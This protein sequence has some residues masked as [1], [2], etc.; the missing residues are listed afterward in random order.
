M[1]IVRSPFGAVR[2]S[3]H[4]IRHVDAALRRDVD[5]H[6]AL[7]FAKRRTTRDA[8]HFGERAIDL[9]EIEVLDHAAA[10]GRIR[11]DVERDALTAGDRTVDARKRILDLAPVRPSGA[12]VMRDVHVHVAFAADLQRLFDRLEQAVAFVAHVR[13]VKATE[14][15]D[16]AR[17]FDHFVGAAPAPGTVDEARRKT[18]RAL[19]HR[20][21]DVT[22]H[23]REFR[24]RRRALLHAER[25][26]A[27]RV[28]ADEHHVVDRGPALEHR[29]EIAVEVG[30]LTGDAGEDAAARAECIDGRVRRNRAETAVAADD[31]G[32]ALREF[33]FHAGV[34]EKR[35]VVVCVRVDEARRE[36][37]PATVDF[38]RARPGATDRRNAVAVDL[39][40]RVECGTAAAVE[41][42]YVAYDEVA[43]RR[44]STLP[45]TSLQNA[46]MSARNN[47]ASSPWLPIFAPRRP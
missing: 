11:I 36:A 10:A 46:I 34:A 39:D 44:D 35:A 37:C 1:Q 19:L 21:F 5:E 41:Y 32:H 14:R 6:A 40:V 16:G 3:S 25:H 45:S 22:A 28:V 29:G 43:H 26:R 47:L 7:E 30:E 31:G 17:E 8:D 38:A 9:R 18:A 42:F 2:I 4:E 12:L 20:A 13:R 33:E 23:R 27:H 15:F 24:I